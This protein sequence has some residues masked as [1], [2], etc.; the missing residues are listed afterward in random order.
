MKNSNVKIVKK[1]GFDVLGFELRTTTKDNKNFVDIPEFWN[2]LLDKGKMDD[3]PNK[4]ESDIYFGICTDCGA[5]GAFSY[6]VGQEVGMI[7]QVPE[8]MRAIS[9]KDS[10]Y[11]ISSTDDKTPEI[12]NKTF[13]Y[14]FEKWL[15]DSK[16]MRDFGDDFELYRKI[17]G[18]MKKNVDIHIPIKKNGR[19]DLS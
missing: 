12:V 19:Y 3:I 17:N 6:I 2:K 8:D 15:P 7:S 9:L 1:E 10:E 16:Y 11:A 18:K 13:E 5:D 4:V 14:I